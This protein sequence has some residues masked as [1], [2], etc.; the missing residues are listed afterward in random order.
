ML[1]LVAAKATTKAAKATTKAAKAKR[2]VYRTKGRTVRVVLEVVK[3][4]RAEKILRYR[5]RRVLDRPPVRP[6]PMPT[7]VVVVDAVTF[8]AR[9]H[10]KR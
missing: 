10:G 2:K 6:T 8:L 3:A 9:L 5:V 4:E 1:H 7:V